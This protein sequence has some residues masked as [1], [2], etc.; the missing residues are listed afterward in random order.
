MA[1]SKDKNDPAK[2]TDNNKSGGDD[3]DLSK[4][5]ADQLAKVLENPDLF[6]TPRIKELLDAQKELKKL[7]EDADKKAD[8]DL[9]EQKKW[10][11]LANK[12]AEEITQLNSKVSELQTNQALTTALTKENV[13]DLDGALKLVDR[14]KLKFNDDGTIEGVDEALSSLKTDK[15]YLFQPGSQPKVGAASNNNAGGDGSGGPAKF[16]R[17][18]LRDPAFYK[19]HEKDILAANDAGLIE[20]DISSQAPGSAN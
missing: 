3:L 13:V 17:S 10:E 2:K 9:A 5:S 20:D 14:G 7:K 15:S 8:D 18:Q 11:D 16:K 4:L 6:K 12:R 19:E 1:D